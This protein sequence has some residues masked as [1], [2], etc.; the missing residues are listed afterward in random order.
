[1]N[2]ET[3]ENLELSDVSEETKQK[4][5]NTT[6]Q[7]PDSPIDNPDRA[8]RLK[9]KINNLLWEE[10]PENT[11]MGKAEA[12]ACDIFSHIIKLYGA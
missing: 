8:T 9:L 6:T 2:A 3:V 1:M 11:T 4:F 12:M 10:L 5:V 7:L